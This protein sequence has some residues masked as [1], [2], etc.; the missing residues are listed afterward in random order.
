MVVGIDGGPRSDKWSN[1][2]FCEGIP[3]AVKL[4]SLHPET[5]ERV[6]QRRPNVASVA[7]LVLD[8]NPI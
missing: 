3:K 6:V 8:L 5:K 1:Q 7:F 4:F 2:C